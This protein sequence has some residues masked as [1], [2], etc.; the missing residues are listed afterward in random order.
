MVTYTWRIIFHKFKHEQL[1]SI[2]HATTCR[3]RNNIEKTISI[4]KAI[5]KNKKMKSHRSA[6]KSVNKSRSNK[7]F[8]NLPGRVERELSALQNKA[9]AFW[10]ATS[11]WYI[12][13]T[14]QRQP[15]RLQHKLISLHYNEPCQIYSS[16][17]TNA[18]ST[19]EGLQCASC[20]HSVTDSVQQRRLRLLCSPPG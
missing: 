20:L 1:S 5:K 16:D 13:Q 7:A 2:S 17:N 8:H 15:W 9:G 6:R 11:P 10:P 14:Y 19:L 3:Q 4:N 12:W 18:F